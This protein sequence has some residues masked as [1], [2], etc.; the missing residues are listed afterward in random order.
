[1]RTA[2][3][4]KGQPSIL[5]FLILILAGAMPLQAQD[6]CRPPMPVAI[7]HMAN[8]FNEQQEVDL[9]DAMAEHLQR[10]YRV[11]NDEQF[12]GYL[13]HV[14]ER[15]L[16]H[17]PVTH[18]PLRL[19]LVD[20]PY[21]NAFDSPGGRI[22]I[23]LKLVALARSEDELAG[24]LAHELGH[25]V[26]HQGALDVSRDMKLALNVTEVSDR[27]DI[28]DK[29]NRL[30]E[31]MWRKRNVLRRTSEEEGDEEQRVADRL[32]L[33]AVAAS[34]YS[35]EA[36]AYI[37]DRIAG[38]EGKTG[39]WLTDFFGATRPDSK[40]LR[41]IMKSPEAIPE[42]CAERAPI[43]NQDQFKTWQAAVIDN[44]D[45]S[46]QELLHGV[47]SKTPLTPPLRG[48]IRHLKFSPDGEYVLAQDEGTIYILTLRP[49]TPL[50]QINAPEAAAAQF[51]PDSKSVVFNNQNLRVETWN[52]ATKIR[53]SAHE[54]V[55]Q[56]GCYQS[57]LSPDGKMLACLEN[58]KD[59]VL[60][61]VATG[62]EV[63]RKPSFSP[64]STLGDLPFVALMEQF[65]VLFFHINLINE[66]FSPDA[67]YFLADS[68]TSTLLFD[69]ATRQALSL[70]GSLKKHVAGRF[71]FLGNGKVVAFNGD[72]PAKSHVISFP[73]GE[74][75]AEV[76][77]GSA[78]LD[79]ATR[80]DYVMLRPIKDYGV[81]VV[82]LAGGK[83]IFAHTL[84]A[85]DIYDRKFV[86][87][88]RNGE[89]GLYDIQ[90]YQAQ[91]AK[92]SLP[93]GN[94]GALRVRAISSD[95]KWLAASE[96][97]RGAVWN[98]ESGKR[99]YYIRGFQGAYFADGG[100]IYADFPKYEEKERE[101]ARLDLAAPGISDAFKIEEKR[102]RQYGRYLLLAKPENKSAWHEMD[103]KVTLEVEDARTGSKLWSRYFP[104][105]M[106]F[107]EVDSG[108]DTTLMGWDASSGTAK[109]EI[110]NFP[111]VGELLS[112]RKEKRNAFL[113]EVME[114]R[115]GKTLGAIAVDTGL[116]YLSLKNA[117]ASGGWVAI[118]DNNNRILL[119]SL[120][121][122]KE[123]GRFFG[124]NSSI[125]P[126][127]GLLCVEN[128][129]GHLTLYDINSGQDLDRWVFS[130]PVLLHSFSKDG[131][132][133]FVLTA[134]QTAYVLDVFASAGPSTASAAGGA[135]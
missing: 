73:Q 131:K 65:D 81:G 107:L 69:T 21:A 72:N 23:S 110:K 8:I 93:G 111:A 101:I 78:D 41:E 33:Y 109:E 121:S 49:F 68:K 119:Y 51:S 77:L 18:L 11:S 88:E 28:F 130:S 45:W 2:T 106:P 89:L 84:P 95:W 125:S 40:R 124:N 96:E 26:A 13:R 132:R 62:E 67:R 10:N 5:P 34:G 102:T 118:S 9:G 3:R 48:E 87:E 122:G 42:G 74:V 82:D 115:T 25:M 47:L 98:L 20:L 1:M 17:L 90:N 91:I 76:S 135:E 30:I 55:V 113:V 16:N 126:T 6:A 85:L 117:R 31:G 70:P 57:D 4:K 86:C 79:G 80:G 75:L 46:N 44:S 116:H 12:V 43:T 37:F 56:K 60:I 83:Y 108:D 103:H 133:L 92:T 66:H 59:L 71:A 50:F 94:L 64:S 19:S 35:T 24:V 114:A 53:T 105:E 15:L 32:A 7:T 63:F 39:N 29:Y 22:Y 100:E 123:V 58:R 52:I 104:N 61:D 27:R 112:S 129:S 128:E 54:M 127:N 38:T 99:L 120:S 36:F 97:G 14:A 134:A